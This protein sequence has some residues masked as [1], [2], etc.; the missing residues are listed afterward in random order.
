MFSWF[1]GDY[2]SRSPRLLIPGRKTRTKTHLGTTNIARRA[3][4]F[5]L[6]RGRTSPFNSSATQGNL[7][8]G[9]AAACGFLL[10]PVRIPGKSLASGANSGPRMLTH[11]IAQKHTYVHAHFIDLHFTTSHCVYISPLTPSASE[12]M[13][14][15]R[16]KWLTF[17]VT[18]GI[19]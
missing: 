4:S 14:I 6:K 2:L 19:H 15:K 8:Y 13:Q 7:K 16:L 10:A 17:P 3:L 12:Q 11:P 9:S 5:Q 18:E 1:W